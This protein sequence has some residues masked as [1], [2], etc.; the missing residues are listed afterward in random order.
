MKITGVRTKPFTM[1]LDRPLGDANNPVGSNRMSGLAV[2]IDTDDGVT[3]T[4]LGSMSAQSHIQSLVND[5]LIG[6]DPR[7]VRGL[8]KKMV[9]VAFKG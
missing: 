3:G 1:I 8:W 2:Y 7:G 5:L 4:S 6:H 9:D